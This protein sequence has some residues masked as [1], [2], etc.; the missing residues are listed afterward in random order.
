MATYPTLA[1]TGLPIRKIPVLPL[2]VVQTALSGKETR[3]GY[4]TVTRMEYE[5]PID[6]MTSAERASFLSWIT[7]A[8]GMLTTFT[9]TDPDTAGSV[10]VRIVDAGSLTRL[11]HDGWGNTNIRL[12]E[13]I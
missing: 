12:I 1:L 2:V 11:F 5:I 13:V 6:L 10:T 7:A 9:I 3:I 4:S 8:G